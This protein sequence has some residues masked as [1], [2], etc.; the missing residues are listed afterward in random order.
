MFSVFRKAICRGDEIK[1][2]ADK[3]PFDKAII[4][5]YTVHN[6]NFQEATKIAAGYVVATHT[7]LHKVK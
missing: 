7:A 5:V 6:R 1:I 2:I 3:K 4:L